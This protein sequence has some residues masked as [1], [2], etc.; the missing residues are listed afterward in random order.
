MF[1]YGLIVPILPFILQD[2]LFLPRSSVQK[3]SSILLACQA[4][5]QLLFSLPAGLLAD[6]MS[7]RQ[8]PFLCG[9]VSLFAATI[10]LWFGQELW[11][12]V[13]A[14]LLQGISASV[15]WTVGMALVHDTVG[16]ERLGIVIGTIFSIIGVGEVIAPV[17][18]GV[19][20]H[21]AGE[22]AVFLIGLTLLTIDFIMRMFLIEKKVAA[23]YMILVEDVGS[24]DT[25]ADENEEVDETT[26]LVAKEDPDEWNIPEDQPVWIQ[27]FPILYCLRNPRFFTAQVGSFMQA[28]LLGVY[29]STIPTET[30]DL[31]GFNS[32]HTGLVFV[33]LVLTYLVCGPIAGRGVD[34]YGTKPAATF[35][36]LWMVIPLTLL[37]IPKSGDIVLYCALLA[38]GGIGLAFISSPSIV[39]SNHVVERYYKANKTFFGAKGPHAQMYAITS[40]SFCLGLTIGPLIAGFLRLKIG[41]GNMNAVIAC[42]SLLVGIKSFVYLGGQPKFSRR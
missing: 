35:G 40:I 26:Q 12:L 6:R 36:F 17:V 7:S 20:Y 34:K 14:R 1:L 4:G 37:R 9:L 21:K 5:A 27:T 13:V 23:K 38:L 42:M 32:M 3:Y 30:V 2:R 19:L 18:G 8:L 29:D 15:V 11:V 24:E 31:F 39:E 41:Y 28:T 22:A 33:P 25:L 16:N 10:L